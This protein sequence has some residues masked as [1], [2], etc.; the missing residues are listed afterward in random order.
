M[1][2]EQVRADLCEMYPGWTFETI[3]GMSF[4]QI[5]SACRRGRK[6]KLVVQSIEEAREINRNWRE[7]Y[8][9]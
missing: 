5:D 7:Y 3:D 2:Y 4:E 6:E 9:L 1:S 8:G